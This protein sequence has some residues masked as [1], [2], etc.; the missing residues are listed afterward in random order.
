[1]SQWRVSLP[2]VSILI[3]TYN[4]P[5]YLKLALES[6]LAQTYPNIEIIIGD[7]ST[8][9]ETEV[10]LKPYLKKYPFIK[11]LKRTASLPC[12]NMK[13][14]FQLA[15]GE[16]INFL[17]DDDLFYPEKITK[18]M[19]YFSKNSS[20]SLVTS[21]RDLID[22][23]GNIMHIPGFHKYIAAE[24]TLISGRE[25]GTRFMM[26][27]Y[28][29]IGEPTTPL[30]RKRDLPEGWASYQGLQYTA[31]VDMASWLSLL[32]KG[33][34]V[35]IVE[36]LSCFRIHLGQGNHGQEWQQG[37]F[38]EFGI[39]IHD[40]H[41]LDQHHAERN[42]LLDGYMQLHGEQFV[43]GISECMSPYVSEEVRGR[44]LEIFNA[45]SR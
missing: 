14:C 24:D 29:F 11:Y 12:D 3:P 2:K 40:S 22:E 37:A 5:H 4:R 30:F 21:T 18:M 31:L 36:P 34:F 43:Y 9:N 6:A 7:D 32:T 41:F 27:G 8:N 16:F 25:L 44:Y 10:M 23:E 45:D 20:V 35:Y 33:D 26:H 42:A 17:M 15:S 1:M 28:N 19:N 13:E 38:Y 39:L